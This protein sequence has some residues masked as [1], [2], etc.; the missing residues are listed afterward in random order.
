MLPTH[1]KDH[2]LFIAFAPVDRP[3][4]ALAIVIEN[5]GS[6]GQVAAPIARRIFDYY[7]IERQRRASQSAVDHF[8]G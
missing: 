6:G 5:G 8:H 2:A 7:F 1:L 4:V 3:R